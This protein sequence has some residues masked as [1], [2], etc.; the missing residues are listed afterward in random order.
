MRGVSLLGFGCAHMSA[1]LGGSHSLTFSL[2]V[3]HIHEMSSEISSLFRDFIKDLFQILQWL[4][5]QVQD[6]WLSF[7]SQM[8]SPWTLSRRCEQV[9]SFLCGGHRELIHK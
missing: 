9:I 5:F 7:V 3:T 1:L 6:R 2:A 8:S 4:L